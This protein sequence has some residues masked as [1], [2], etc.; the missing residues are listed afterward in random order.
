MISLPPFLSLSLS[1]SLSLPAF[2]L[3]SEMQK[4]NHRV[5]QN[6]FQKTDAAVALDLAVAI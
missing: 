3:Q 6:C 4:A 1:L 2:V 5:S